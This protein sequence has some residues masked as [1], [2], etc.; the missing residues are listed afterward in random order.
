MDPLYIFGLE[1]SVMING[2][3][4]IAISDVWIPQSFFNPSFP[5]RHDIP[6]IAV[7]ASQPLP[8]YSLADVREFNCVYFTPHQS[9]TQFQLFQALYHINQTPVS[10]KYDTNHDMIAIEYLKHLPPVRLW[11]HETFAQLVFRETSTLGFQRSF[12]D[13]ITIQ[14]ESYYIFDSKKFATIQNKLYLASY[15]PLKDEMPSIKPGHLLIKC[16]ETKNP[17]CALLYLGSNSPSNEI[18]ID[19]SDQHKYHHF[20]IKH[21]T[22]HPLLGGT[23][24]KLTFSL[25]N[26]QS[27]QIQLCPQGPPIVMKVISRKTMNSS[28]AAYFEGANG[29]EISL[30]QP[31]VKNTGRSLYQ[32]GISSLT[33][34]TKYPLGLSE[35]ERAITISIQSPKIIGGRLLK[36]TIKCPEAL[37]SVEEF[38]RQLE[39]NTNGVL[40]TELTPKLKIKHQ[41]KDAKISLVMSKRLFNILGGKTD[42]P[43]ETINIEPEGYTFGGLPQF[44]TIQPVYVESTLARNGLLKILP[45]VASNKDGIAHF[46]FESVD[47]YP[48]SVDSVAKLDISLKNSKGELLPMKEKVV[49]TFQFKKVGEVIPNKYH[50]CV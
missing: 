19:Y 30:S 29:E 22:F 6:L 27:E 1:Q 2:A 36:Y 12:V 48:M 33:F 39:Y 8:S 7:E 38:A 28:K 24:T 3:Y 50:K 25:Q 13:K 31:L 40:D 44:P 20:V 41:D 5:K 10:V 35:E 11:L 17:Q 49:A 47:Y 15:W 37:A 46:D 43:A 18:D 21:P 23:H 42:Q 34:S 14:D 45:I 16:F 9:I 4:E 26:L 32:I